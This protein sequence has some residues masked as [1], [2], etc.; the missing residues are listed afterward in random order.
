[1]SKRKTVKDIIINVS[2]G[3]TRIA[4]LEDQAMVELYVER[5]ESERMVGD[6]YKG[7]VTNTVE[8]IRAGFVNIG[9]KQNGFLPEV[10]STGC[11]CVSYHRH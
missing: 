2:S 8:A 10:H 9:L 3:E 5:P 7:V 6:I 4:I 11:Q 1:M